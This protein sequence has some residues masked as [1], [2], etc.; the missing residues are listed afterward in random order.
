M[1][2]PHTERSVT[3]ATPVSI[4]AARERPAVQAHHRA[5]ADDAAG[6]RR[7]WPRHRDGCVPQRLGVQREEGGARA[8]RPARRRTCVRRCATL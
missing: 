5:A 4:G 1:W 2:A 8:A 7:L 6:G 3:P